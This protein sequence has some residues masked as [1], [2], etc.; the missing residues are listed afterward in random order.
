MVKESQENTKEKQSEKKIPSFRPGDTVT[1]G[2]KITEGKKTRVQDFTGV[3]IAI[4]GKEDYKTF[5]VRK[6]AS[7]KIGVERIFPLF[8]PKLKKLEVVKKGKPR[9]SKLY[10]LR[11]RVGKRA[12]KVKERK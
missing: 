11:G 10:Y 5:T 4:K 6:I 3:V 9:R 1:V 2:W 8:S 7:G 12:L